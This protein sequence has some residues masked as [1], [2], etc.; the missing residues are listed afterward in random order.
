MYQHLIL[1]FVF[2]QMQKHTEIHISQVG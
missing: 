2:K 1:A